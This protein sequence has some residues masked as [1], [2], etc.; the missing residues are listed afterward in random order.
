M[1]IIRY[2]SD[3]HLERRRGIIKL[4]KESL[5]S[6]IILAG[7]I[8]SPLKNNYWN[9]ISY[10]SDNFENVYF[11]TGNHE[12]W[13]NDGLCIEYINNI[14]NEKSLIYNNIH[15]LNNKVIKHDEYDIIGTI[16]WSYP[17]LSL[18]NSFDF[19]MIYNKNLINLNHYSMR[20]LYLENKIWLENQINK[21]KRKKIIVTHYLP[22]FDFCMKRY[23][24]IKASSFFASDLDNLIKSPVKYWIFG[25]THDN[26]V[27]KKNNVYCCVNSIGRKKNINI[28]NIIL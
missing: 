14:I 21:N 6:S 1:R 22:S 8:G 27:S 7:D 10:L 25:H 9:F 15:F 16:L 12:Y 28:R 26:F 4:P 2:I 5:G 19:K 20:N 23:R 24:F 18:K 3:L 11:T 13:N 17:D